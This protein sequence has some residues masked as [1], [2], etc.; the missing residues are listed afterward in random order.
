MNSESPCPCNAQQ[1]YEQ[2]CGPLLAGKTQA[3]TAEQLMRSRFSAFYLAD[4]DYLIR[5]HHP[6]QRQADDREGLTDSVENCQWHS[7][8][9]ILSRQGQ[10][11][12]H[13]GEV[14]FVAYYSK[15]QQMFQLHENSR[16]VKEQ[17]RWFY[18]DGDQLASQNPLELGRNEPCWCGSGSKF[19]RCH[20]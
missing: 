13:S 19:K 1:R 8:Q 18:V 10:A 9:I 7:L 11:Q 15:Q 3:K 14:E 16:F 12:Q 2:C 4:I 5:T 17:D 20:G 6:S